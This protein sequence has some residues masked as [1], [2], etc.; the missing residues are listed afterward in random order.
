M[1]KKDETDGKRVIALAMKDA[2]NKK[3][4]AGASAPEPEAVPP[5]RGKRRA[6]YDTE[7]PRECPVEPL[8][9]NGD[10]VYFLD[11]KR[12]LRTLKS[13]DVQRSVILALF[14]EKTDCLYDFWPRFNK[15]GKL[16]G[17]RPEQGGETLM[18][19]AAKRGIWDIQDRV[20]G[21][22]CWTDDEGKL[23][24][25]CGDVMIRGG[26]TL[27]PGTIGRHVYP[28]GPPKPR[29]LEGDG[30][31]A[32]AEELLSLIKTWNWRRKDIDPHFLLGWI[33]AAMVGGALDWRPMVWVT[34]D[35]ATGKSTLQKVISLVMGPGGILSS[36]DATAAGL[37]QSV[38]HA[39]LPVALDEL[40]AMEDNRKSQNI[41]QLARV[42]SSG[43]QVL[44]GGSDH[45]NAS[46]TVRSCFLFSSILI[47][48]MLGQDISRMAILALDELQET[49]PPVLDK[50]R[51]YNI[52]AALRRRLLDKWELLQRMIETYKHQL[53][54]AG[55]GG[56]GADQFGT[57]LACH[58]VL[59]YDMEASGDELEE[60]SRKLAKNNLAECESD[61]P[62]HQRC[63]DFLLSAH[64][65]LWRGGERKNVADWIRQ[66][67]GVT[68]YNNDVNITDAEKAL[69]SIGV[70][71]LRDTRPERDFILI[72]NAHAGLADLYR[73][74]HW[75]G[76]SGT[77]GVW[78]QALRRIPGACATKKRIGGV[79][80]RCTEIP[81]K[82]ILNLD[83]K[84]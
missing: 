75:A 37:W 6:P 32:A 13:K 26:E 81:L 11:Q 52:G 9:I 10:L 79:S 67:A 21:A 76:R 22:G 1:A 7:F 82:N 34:G 48:P 51:L 38:G 43:G 41:I 60:W 30:Q 40:E 49:A 39:S 44:R 25:H 16:D 70:R 62:D 64:A 23:V 57:L 61:L 33:G 69:G 71:I 12:Q 20:R 55:H 15:D 31:T 63:I 84:D 8:G 17:W 54:T 36:T 29:P 58:D 24:M 42:A 19:E 80:L 46:F 74:T 66:A 5:R 18:K 50:I 4:E 47:P 59:L 83:E 78:T 65:D 27:V 28:S 14:G 35:K 56:R 68:S 2:L 73:E 53:A 77:D 72:A 45:K 3:A